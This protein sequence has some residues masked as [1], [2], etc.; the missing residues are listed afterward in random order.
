MNEK[1]NTAITAPLRNNKGFTL[2]EMAI[3]LVIIGIII[4]AVVK[5]Q[6]LIVNAQAKQVTSAVNSWR[7]L[8]YA[9]LDRNGRFPGD[10][11]RN[12]IIGDGTTAPLENTAALSAVTELANTMQNLPANPVVIGSMSFF[13]YPGSV[14]PTVGNVRNALV[15][16]K[17][18]ACTGQ[19][20][21][22]EIEIIKALD[23]AIDGTADAGMGQLRG[24]TA[25]PTLTGLGAWTL[26]SGR[27][28]DTLT[29]AT[30]SGTATAVVGAT[31]PWAATTFNA[32]VWLFDRPFP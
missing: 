25:A 28:N 21:A 20:T 23:T 30:I 27:A 9:F 15:I 17:S 22:D 4:G 10:E 13:V 2:I 7:S 16:C 31:A 3:V 26:A 14:T 8:T 18:A 19:F 5:G 24:V 1:S 29:A 12:G 32:A 6:D 11:G